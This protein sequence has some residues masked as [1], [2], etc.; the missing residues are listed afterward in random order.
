MI[1]VVRIGPLASVQDLGRDGYRSV[2]LSSCGA[3][4]K[5][6]LEIGN[7]LLGNDATSAGIEMTVPP[8]VLRFHVRT[9]IA[10]TGA[11]ASATLNGE[12]CVQPWWCMTVDEGDELEIKRTRY[13]ARSYLAVKGGID[14]C[15]VLGSRSTDLK[16]GFGGYEG[17]ALR[18]GDRIPLLSRMSDGERI[19]PFGVL[20]PWEA[21]PIDG[22]TALESEEMVV[23]VL[24]ASEYGKFTRES[25]DEL[26]STGWTVESE[27]NRIGYRLKGPALRLSASLEML[28]HGIVPGVIQVPPSGQPIIAMADAQA[29][30]GYPKIGT[31]IEADL[32]RL[33]QTNLGKQIRFKEC[34][35]EQAVDAYTELRRYINHLGDL[36]WRVA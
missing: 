17:R 25:I 16:V 20:S 11:V 30:G 3:M 15:Q 8:T 36:W 7:I 28:S 27:S 31:V 13:G 33:A 34:T 23:R 4:D 2:G 5:V 10:L 14:S 26:W 12:A 19:H 24:P 1:E 6:A 21:L 18:K 9:S 35:L 32:W 29:S 22:H